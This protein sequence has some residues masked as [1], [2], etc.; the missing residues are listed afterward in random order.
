MSI[1]SS[2]WREYSKMDA[3]LEAVRTKGM[4]IDAFC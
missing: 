2:T 4:F 3:E 1:D